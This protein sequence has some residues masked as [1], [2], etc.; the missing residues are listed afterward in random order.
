ML[1][2]IRPVI[3]PA[4][5]VA[6]GPGGQS[7]MVCMLSTEIACC[8]VCARQAIDTVLHPPMGLNLLSRVVIQSNTE[9]VHALWA[10]DGDGGL[11]CP[12][13]I[14]FAF[15]APGANHLVFIS[16]FCHTFPPIRLKSGIHHAGHCNLMATVV[17]H[18]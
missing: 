3:T 1:D 10:A 12:F 5:L 2:I 8:T 13:R 7:V 4:I 11:A 16:G 6:Q 18:V 15:G 9:K 14:N 17:R